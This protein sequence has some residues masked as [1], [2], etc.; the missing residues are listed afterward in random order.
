MVQTEWLSSLILKML[1][2]EF[3]ALDVRGFGQV[4]TSGS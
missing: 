1:P 4:L 2:L 3:A